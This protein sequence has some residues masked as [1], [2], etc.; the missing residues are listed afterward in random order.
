MVDAAQP[1]SLL[2]SR[3]PP[4]GAGVNQDPGRK[5]PNRGRFHQTVR[6][7]MLMARSREPHDDG[8]N[9]RP[10]RAAL[11][12][13][14]HGNES[15]LQREM[16][17]R[18]RGGVRQAPSA[19]QEATQRL[20]RGGRPRRTVTEAAGEA[21]GLEQLERFELGRI[22]RFLGRLRSCSAEPATSRAG[23]VRC[24]HWGHPRLASTHS[25]NRVSGQVLAT[26]AASTQ[27]RRA[28]ATP[29][30]MLSYSVV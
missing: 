11:Q 7:R 5:R 21:Q 6:N 10:D 27:P 2:L 22:V 19:Q 15:L 9:P 16:A 20:P 29:Q 30:R 28:L 25:R 24:S 14:H 18:A 13:R 8:P 17:F 12:S 26:R 3:R 4:S 23:T 1:S